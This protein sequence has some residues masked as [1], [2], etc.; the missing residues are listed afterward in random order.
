VEDAILSKLK[1]KLGGPLENEA[2]VVYVMVEI[3][4]YLD[5]TDPKAV[6]FKVLRTYCDWVVHLFLDR[7]GAKDVLDA[8]DNAIAAGESDEEVRKKLRKR[9]EQISLNQ[10]RSELQKFLGSND[11]PR[12]VVDNDKSWG[13]FLK[14]YVAAVSDCAFVS[15]DPPGH[16]RAIRRATLEINDNT[17]SA[18]L[19][20]EGVVNVTWLWKLELADDSTRRVGVTYGYARD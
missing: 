11:L 1:A 14:H 7:G 19:S 20:Q 12:I 15:K 8:L 2:E 17:K 18:E 13:Q 10:F 6:E 5:H 4:K 3:R 16:P 9:H